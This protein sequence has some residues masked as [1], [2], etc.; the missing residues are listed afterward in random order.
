MDFL[1]PDDETAKK[2]CGEYASCLK[3]KARSLSYINDVSERFL[4][5]DIEKSD[6]R[7]VT[8][9][10]DDTCPYVG[11]RNTRV[12]DIAVLFLYIV[13]FLGYN[14]RHGTQIYDSDGGVG[15]VRRKQSAFGSLNHLVSNNG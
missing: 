14:I 15:R 5:S 13:V 12:C 6:V 10:H 8:P 2:M 1:L 9:N 11:T 3:N 4:Q 7:N